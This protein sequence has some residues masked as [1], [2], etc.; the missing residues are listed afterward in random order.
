MHLES[1]LFTFSTNTFEPIICAIL[2]SR[3]IIMNKVESVSAWPSPESLPES[4]L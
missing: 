2:C 1:S 3:D 4:L